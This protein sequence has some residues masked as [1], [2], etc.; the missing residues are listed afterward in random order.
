MRDRPP[1]WRVSQVSSV[2]TTSRPRVVRRAEDLLLDWLGSALAG[3]GARAVESIEH[4]ARAMGPAEGPSEVLIARRGT[5]PLFA[6][7]VNA[8]AS[9]FAEQDDVHNGS[10]F[11]PGAV[12]FPPALALAQAHSASGRDFITAAVAGYEVGIRVGEFLG[13]SHYRVFHTTGTAG[14]VAAAAAAGRVLALAP[15]PMLHALGSAGTQAAGLW[16]FL[17]D[18]A[19]SKQLHTAKAASDGSDGCVPR[20]GR[21]H[22]RTAHSR[23]R[24]GHGRRHVDRRGSARASPIVSVSAGRSKKRRSSSTRRAGTRIPRRT[25]CSSSSSR[26][27]WHPRTS[28][29]SPRR[30]IRRAIDVLGPVIDPRTVHQAKFSMGTVLGV[31]A[32]YRRAGLAEFQQHFRDPRIVAFRDR[33]RMTQD[34]EVEAAYPR[35]WIGKV[36]VE[37]ADGRTL[38][39]ARRRTE[40]RPRQHTLARRARSEGAASRRMERRGNAGRDAPGDRTHLCDLRGA[41]RRAAHDRRRRRPC[42]RNAPAACSVVAMTNALPESAHDVAGF[43]ARAATWDDDPAKVARARAIADAIV[44]EVPLEQSMDALEY[45]AGTGLVG[46]MLRPH[47]ADVTLADLSE[48]MLAV[49]D[50][51]IRAAGDAHMRAV[52]LDLLDEPLHDLRY[53]VILSAMTLHHIPDTAAILKRFHDVLRAPGYL[54]IADLDREDGSFHGAGFDGHLGFDREGL[55]KL[56][57][58]AGFAAVRFVTAYTMT[59]DVAGTPHTFPIFLMVARTG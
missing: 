23:R 58:S 11:H 47:L 32:T 4:F 53:D 3:K 22:R 49:A 38:V 1:C 29:V 13:R 9:H 57:K 46:F 27:T 42:R 31:I 5:S 2:S 59:K 7:M 6:A 35:Q 14:T 50:A 33:V 17:R 39:G 15:A 41:A 18:A 30:C 36:E 25:R 52:R 20:A 19:D 12:V 24:A 37:T 34:A 45:G 40:G 8:G 16:E 44:R 28:C 55:A 48:G 43:D 21:L 54:C 26:T 56:A 10:V 51:K